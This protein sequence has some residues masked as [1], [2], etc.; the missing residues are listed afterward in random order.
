MRYNHHFYAI[1]YTIG[2]NVA[3]IRSMNASTDCA[4]DEYWNSNGNMIDESSVIATISA[5][6]E[7]GNKSNDTSST[8]IDSW[9]ILHTS[10]TPAFIDRGIV[11]Y[12][13]DVNS[14]KKSTT[15]KN[16]RRGNVR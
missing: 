8:T 14:C 15:P 10:R 2:A 7:A 5:G 16:T 9:S 4:N 3:T 1:Y 11:T 12:T 13:T 6:D